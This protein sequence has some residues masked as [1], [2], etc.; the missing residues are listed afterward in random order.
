MVYL[1][2]SEGKA[3]AATRAFGGS[4]SPDTPA[5][6]VRGR[7]TIALLDRPAASLL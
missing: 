4:P 3:E 1:V 2:T 7:R 5:S 6:L